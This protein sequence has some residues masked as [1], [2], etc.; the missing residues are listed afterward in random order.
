MF[1]STQVNTGDLRSALQN[2]QVQETSSSGSNAFMKFDYKTGGF[3]FGRDNEDISGEEIVVNI[4]TF[5]HGWTI[6]AEGKPHKT[7]VPFTAPLPLEPASIGDNHASESRSFEARFLDDD[8]TILQFDI[9]SYGGRKGCDALL[10]AVKVRASIENETHLF[11]VVKLDNESYKSKQG[12][13]IHNPVFTVVNWMD[14]EG[15]LFEQTPQL[16]A[17]PEPEPEPAPA[18]KRRRRKA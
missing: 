18:P 10:N 9:N 7:V 16:E 12:S 2:S 1:P 11:P 6:W 14:D 4:A 3:T 8:E 15:N 13:T 5:K 17:Q